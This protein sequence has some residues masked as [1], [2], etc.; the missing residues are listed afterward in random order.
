MK[1][2][3]CW[4][5]SILIPLPILAQKSE[6][7]IEFRIAFGSCNKQNE[8]NMLWKEVKKNAPNLWIWGGDN[9]YADTNDMKLMMQKY[10]QQIQQ[11]DYQDF[12]SNVQLM[13]VWDDHDY[14]KNDA[15]VEYQKKDSAQ[16]LFLDFLDIDKNDPLRNQKGIYTSKVFSLANG[17]IKVITLDTRYFRTQLSKSENKRYKPN[18]YGEGTILGEVQWK[19]LKK[20][21]IESNANFNLIVSSIQIL[22]SEHGFEK[23]ANFPH[24][25]D[26]L[27]TI[28]KK[29]KAKGVL[30]LSGDR[31]LS[32]FS[33]I[34][35]PNLAY[36]LID[37]TSSGLT[38]SY[39]SYTSEPNK[40]RVKEVVSSI[41]FGVLKFD[42]K[43]NKVV[44]QMRGENNALLQ[45]FEQ[46]YP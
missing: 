6:D 24:E 12:I 29:S 31:H 42:L 22:S 4:F 23:W 5:V 2:L 25:L 10:Q 11:N 3:I 39:A 9:I 46:S 45:Q 28:I 16:Q 34:E 8:K 41:S 35:L 44:M 36:P 37:F 19:W 38:H 32:E 17:K 21:L 33:K 7:S 1:S 30:F 43:N 14:G 18:P 27:F 15:G 40:F 20:E 26:K 13:G